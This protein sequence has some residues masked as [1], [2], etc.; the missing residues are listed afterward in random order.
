MI[1]GSIAWVDCDPFSAA[2]VQAPCVESSHIPLGRRQSCS[3][4][5]LLN[6]EHNLAPWFPAL[7]HECVTVRHKS[8]SPSHVAESI[9]APRPQTGSSFD[10]LHIE[11]RQ[12][13]VLQLNH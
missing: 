8:R 12:F 1:L 13:T 7:A 2:N 5:A 10:A 6:P 9:N 11:A 4:E 3:V